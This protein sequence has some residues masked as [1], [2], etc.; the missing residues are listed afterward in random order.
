VTPEK[1]PNSQ[2]EAFQGAIFADGFKRIFGAGWIKAATR[3]EKRRYT[4]LV[5]LYKKNKWYTH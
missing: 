1:P 5:Q 2:I 4:Y 3:R